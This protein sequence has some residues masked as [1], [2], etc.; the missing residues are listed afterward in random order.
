[1]TAIDLPRAL[2][3]LNQS[4]PSQA[5][6][7]D[8]R[9]SRQKVRVDRSC[10]LDCALQLQSKLDK[11]CFLEV[12]FQGEEG[13]GLGPTLEFYDDVAEKLKQWTWSLADGNPYF[14]W[15][16]C[17][18]NSLFPAPVCA[19]SFPKPALKKIQELFSLCGVLVAKAISDDR[20]LDLPISPLF[21]RLCLG[22][23]ASLLDLKQ[24]DQT[25]F[26]TL[27]EFQHLCN[28]QQQLEDQ[29]QE[30][31]ALPLRNGSFVEDY[32][33]SFTLP[34][35]EHVELVPG[36]QEKAVTQQNLQEYVDRVLHCQFHE[37]LKL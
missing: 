21:W 24:L 13:S 23:S 31:P 32:C 34:C 25:V 9:R 33:L 22:K 8:L 30:V 11:H 35:F 29:G 4:L 17:P 12:E 27:S 18:D 3:F 28:Q 16:V 20:Q 7:K 19:A 26:E 14:L 36:G 15:R 5:K 1:M 6:P 10:L 37:T 2:Y